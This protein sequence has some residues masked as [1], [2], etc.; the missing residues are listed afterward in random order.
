MIVATAG[1]VD[2][3]KTA[4]VK[5]LTGVDADRLPEEKRRGL[6]ID[7][8][9]AYLPLDGGGCIGFVDVP[10]HERFIHNMLAGVS[11]IDGALMVIAADDGPMPQT[12]EHLDILG[13]L[14]VPVCA[15]ALTKVDRVD[16]PRLSEAEREIDTMLTDAGVA[17]APIFPLSA[18]TGSGLE[19]LRRYL[20]QRQR[21][22]PP[23]RSAGLFRMTVD[24]SFTLP[25]AGLMV[26]GTV[27]A[28]EL[29]LG[30]SVYLLRAGAVARVRSMHAQNRAATQAR[31]GD[32]CALN[33]TGLPSSHGPIIRGEVVA[34]AGAAPPAERIDIHLRL[35]PT[36][37]RVLRHWSPVHVHIGAA[38]VAGRVALLEGGALV[39]GG[40]M[41]AQLVLAH[42][43]AACHGDRV[44]LRDPSAQR[45]LGGGK[46]VDVFAP[47]RGR[48]RP[49]RLTAL[50]ALSLNDHQAALAAVLEASPDG[51]NLSRFAAGRN[52]SAEELEACVKRTDLRRIG[53]SQALSPTH[54]QSA[55]QAALDQVNTSL[56]KASDSPGVPVDRVLA[57]SHPQFTPAVRM[58]VAE[59]LVASGQLERS[60]AVLRLPG[61]GPCLNAHDQALWNES[62]RLMA[63]AGLRPPSVA[64]IATATRSAPRQVNDLLGRLALRREVWRISEHRFALPVTVR[65]WGAHLLALGG[66]DG[67][68]RFTASDFRDR[69]GVGRNLSIEILEFFDRIH[70]TRR[71]GDLRHLQ[72][73]PV[74]VQELLRLGT[75]AD[76]PCQ[77]WKR[78]AS[79]GA[80]GLQTR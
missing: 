1:H 14:D 75:N 48:A 35:L 3:G 62:S 69:A 67:A 54:W 64:E 4:L 28:G 71:I 8:G 32:R 56:A 53:T 60:G 10:G 66:S 57:A 6:T 13:L 20:L 34:V 29:A 58:A 26:T 73:R 42:T 72:C 37:R 78:I 76:I 80:P 40:G 44:V 38:R 25:G 47:A 12:R 31:A 22:L 74:E 45:T 49:Q 15:I 24:R 46:V 43:V 41:L 7:L 59:H 36:E 16:A 63:S 19:A 17:P 65:I 11:G 18:V 55:C 23:R 33:L 70:L 50:R 68:T 2:H 52:L 30:D 79:G 39:P 27:L 5:A 61:R 21:E 9:F 77:S 51:L